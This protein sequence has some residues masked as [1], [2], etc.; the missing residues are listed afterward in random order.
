MPLRRVLAGTILGVGLGRRSLVS[1]GARPILPTTDV[2]DDANRVY[3]F[4]LLVMGGGS[5]GL[6]AGKRAA[7][8]G[9]KVAVCDFVS[10]SETKNT[11][12]GLGG[13]CVNVGCIP[14]KLMHQAAH[15]GFEMTT[16]APSFGWGITP[17]PC[18]WGVLRE[19][20]TNYI[21]SLNFGNSSA[22]YERKI[23]YLNGKARLVDPFSVECTVDGVPRQIT[24]RRILIATGGRPVL[25]QIPGA[26]E[27]GVTSDDIFRLEED[28]GETIVVGGSYVGLEC[29]GFLHGI[30]RKVSVLIRSQA[31]RGFDQ[32]MAERVVSHMKSIGVDVRREATV[33]QIVKDAASGR[34][35]VTMSSDGCKEEER[36]VDTVLFATGRVPQSRGLG[37]EESGVD[38]DAS[39]KVVV[40]SCDRTSVPNIYAIGD[41][42]TGGP[43]LTPVAVKAGQLLAERL[44]NKGTSLSRRPSSP[45]SS[46]VVSE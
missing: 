41:V 18:D 42:A 21:R 19:A 10:P 33:S 46:T 34:L 20:V 13:T 39:G 43:E 23:E 25:P 29:A 4:D 26:K 35:R 2:V 40:D 24:A 16:L 3:D 7:D 22:L 6:A 37:L 38:L 31:L 17:K 1:A 12:W 32:D 30:G 9:A 15:I 27:F 44:Y 36:V 45:P 14:K 5:G 11:T 28:P 8:L